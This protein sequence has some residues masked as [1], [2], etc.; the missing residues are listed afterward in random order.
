RSASSM[1]WSTSPD[2]HG[3]PRADPRAGTPTAPSV[4]SVLRRCGAAVRSAPRCCDDE[5]MTQPDETQAGPTQPDETQAGPTQPDET[6]PGPT[7]PDETQPGAT[8]GTDETSPDDEITAF[9]ELA[10]GHAGIGRLASVIGP[11]AAASV[12]PA[13]WA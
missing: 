1:G 5:A 2:H 13:A 4:R 3:R 6:Q 10:R 7:Q 8:H 11:G 9:W 12:P